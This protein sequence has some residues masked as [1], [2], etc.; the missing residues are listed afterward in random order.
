M[1]DMMA[2]MEKRV[3]SLEKKVG[4]GK[5]DMDYLDD[6]PTT[7]PRHENPA[8]EDTGKKKKSVGLMIAMLKARKNK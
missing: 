3:S 4:T 5:K 1:K 8:H 2:A 7:E 6:G